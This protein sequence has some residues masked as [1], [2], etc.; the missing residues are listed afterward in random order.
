MNFYT[1]WEEVRAL[2]VVDEAFFESFLQGSDI[3]VKLF[4]EGNR[5][6]LSSA[7]KFLEDIP[8]ERFVETIGRMDIDNEL[9]T[10]AIP[11]FSSF[12]HGAVRLNEL[13]EF[14]PKGLSYTDIGHQIMN[15]AN[16]SAQLKYGENHAKLAEMMS[17]VI[18][19]YHKPAL[20]KTTALGHHLTAVPWLKK[21]DFLRKLLLR[22]QCV[23][24]L[25]RQ[26]ISGEAVYRDIANRLSESTAIRRRTN[27]KCFM[28]F[29]LEPESVQY[30]LQNINWEI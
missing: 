6:E 28:E 17:L 10:A 23:Q 25:L 9:K 29:I 11:C 3:S 14:A 19:D 30:L 7:I 13:L 1:T 5:E 18:I 15:S 27:V 26:A 2:G 20:V 16:P 22:N 8:I 21:A 24:L 12:L 4:I